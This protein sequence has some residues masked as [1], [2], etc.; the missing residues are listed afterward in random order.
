M[1]VTN[2]G[3]LLIPKEWSLRANLEAESTVTMVGRG[4]YFDIFNSVDYGKV[5]EQQTANVNEAF[6]D[7]GIF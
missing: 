2:Q 5:L 6:G 3:K 1:T 7:L 4:K